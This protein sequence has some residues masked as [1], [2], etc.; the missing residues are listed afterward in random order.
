MP[1]GTNLFSIGRRRGDEDQLTNMVAWLASAVPDTRSALV[2]LVLDGQYDV[3]EIDVRTQYSIPSGRLDAL[4]TG[5]GF[6]LIVE[7][8]LGSDFGSDQIGKYLRWLTHNRSSDEV[9]ALMTLTKRPA[10]W[11]QDDLDYADVNDVAHRARR[12]EELH[13]AFEPLAAGDAHDPLSARLVAQFLEMLTEEG[14]VPIPSM[15]SEDLGARWTES[16]S[17]IRR[18]ADFFGGCKEAIA[19]EL[20]ATRY[21]NRWSDK[22]DWLYQDYALKDGVSVVVGLGHTDEHENVALPKRSP[23]VWVGVLMDQHPQWSTIAEALARS[24]PAG[25]NKGN[26]WY[27]RPTM[28]CY[29]ADV[30]GEGSF[31]EQRDRF[32]AKI[33][34]ARKWIMAAASTRSF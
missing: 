33:S 12:W 30:L 23:I 22:G 9:V 27:G 25:W 32:A 20:D 6:K 5:P 26:E 3:E 7:S 10:P 29:L 17:V 31:D 21:P 2:E 8:K 15:S 1:R 28:W 34:D 4:L 24:R 11:L 18:F 19:R 13:S 16:W 14:L